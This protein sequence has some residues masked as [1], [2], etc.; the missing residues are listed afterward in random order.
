MKAKTCEELRNLLY[1]AAE[2]L[3]ERVAPLYKVLNWEWG[4][5]RRGRGQNIPTEKD[6]CVCL[7]R[8]INSLIDENICG[9]TETGGLFVRIEEDESNWFVGTVGFL[10]TK[11]RYVKDE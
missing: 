4:I 6:I 8:L 11:E 2:E 3:A 10:V 7:I 9:Y 1:N 5:F